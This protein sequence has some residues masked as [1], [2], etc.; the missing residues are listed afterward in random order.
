MGLALGRCLT[1]LPA[2][3]RGE[4]DVVDQQ[5]RAGDLG[6]VGVTLAQAL[7]GRFVLVKGRQELEWELSGAGANF[8]LPE[9]HNY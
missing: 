4:V 6:H 1:R 5:H 2:Q 8:H 3:A 9:N 7:E